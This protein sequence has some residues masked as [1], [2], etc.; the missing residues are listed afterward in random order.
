MAE[1][2]ERPFFIVCSPRSGSTLLRLVLDAHPR[3]SVPPPAWLFH[4]I[5]PYLYSY[6]DLA[7]EENVRVMIEEALATP[8]IVEWPIQPSV[9]EVR[10]EMYS[11]SFAEMYAALHR[12]YARRQGKD[13]WGEKTPRDCFF[14]SEIKL[15]FPG[16][17]FIHILRDG[18]DTAIDI[19]DSILWPNSLYAAALMW[20]DCVLAAESEGKTFDPDSFMTIKYEDLC[21]DPRV[22]LDRLCGFLGEEFS[23]FMLAHNETS[24]THE[25]A[26]EAIHAKTARPIC[27]D[28][29]GMYKQRMRPNDRAVIESLIGDTIAAFGY[30][31]EGTAKYLPER[32]ARMILSTDMISNTKAIDFARWHEKRRKE[33]RDR[34]VWRDNDKTSD[35][36][37][38]H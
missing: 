34:G 33:R 13:R 5:Y 12:L 23:P 20:R 35:L 22:T 17:K 18:R 10:A 9:E 31:L 29:V 14:M 16:A 8:T 7:V 38:F 24:S 25:W 11:T 21:T 19:S 30:P 15:M 37:G 3:L 32:E 26:K 28:F 1:A 27:T 36:L 4:Y 2:Q 6:G